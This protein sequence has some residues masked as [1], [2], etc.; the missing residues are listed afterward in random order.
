MQTLT[1]K[2]ITTDDFKQYF[3]IDLQ[4]EIEGINP[5]DSANSFLVRIEN[6]IETYLNAEFYRNVEVEYPQ[7]TE[8]QKLHYQRALLEQAIFVF[9]NGDL[10]V[11][12]GYDPQ[13]GQKISINALQELC[14][15]PN[16]K[17]ELMLCGLWCRKLRNNKKRFW[18]DWLI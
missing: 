13:S 6:R 8:Y 9:K 4:A 7:F 14:I 18:H 5:Q 3:G 17:R 11:D 10:S 15:A 16:A 1:S 12:S 2:Y